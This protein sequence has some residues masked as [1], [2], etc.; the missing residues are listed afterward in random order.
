MSVMPV[1][2]FLVSANTVQPLPQAHAHND[3][4]HDR[5]LLDALSHGFRGIEADVYLVQGDLWV[6]HDRNKLDASRTLRNLYL[7]PLAERAERSP[8]GIYDDGTGITLLVD[9]KSDAL[10]TYQAL[11]AMLETDYADLVTVYRDDTV[12]PGPVTVIVSG[13]RPR[14][15]MA[16]QSVRYA[17][18]DGRLADLGTGMPAAFNPLVSDRWSRAGFTWNGE[19]PM[20]VEQRQK[21]LDYVQRV[22]AEGKRLRFWSTADTPDMWRELSDAGADL[23]NT[24]DLEGLAAFLRDK[25]DTAIATVPKQIDTNPPLRWPWIAACILLVA[26]GTLVVRR[27]PRKGAT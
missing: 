10:P 24:D 25:R 26:M 3:Y 5:P 23:I 8:G 17:A 7:D 9:I 21:L 1:A 27:G 6:A 16:G 11:H 20:P 14:E 15:Y 19:G 18:Y 13:N 12:T 22:H 2:V 4:L